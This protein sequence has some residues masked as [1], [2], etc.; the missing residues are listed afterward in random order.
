M[1]PG[2]VIDMSPGAGDCDVT[3]GLVTRMS[4]GV[5]AAWQLSG[6]S[7]EASRGSLSGAART[8]L[9]SRSFCIQGC[10]RKR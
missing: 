10:Q 3:R 7:S 8:K 4:L 9:A 5:A 1:S 6:D 2:L